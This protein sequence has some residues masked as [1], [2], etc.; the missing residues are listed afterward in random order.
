ML[1]FAERKTRPSGCYAYYWNC[2]CDCGKEVVVDGNCLK[3]GNVTSCGCYWKEIKTTHGMT[4]TR[5]Y[6]I[7]HTMKSRCLNKNDN[8]YKNYGH[9]GIK[10]CDEWMK[11]EQ[12][13]KWALSNGY[14]DKLTIDRINVNGNY[15]PDNCRWVDVV[16]QN[17]NKNTN[18]V[19]E[20]KGE[21][22]TISELSRISNIPYATLKYR[23]A[24]WNNVE[25]AVE[26][27][28]RKDKQ[29]IQYTLDEVF[30]KKWDNIITASDELKID[31]SGIANCCKGKQKTS[32]GYIW[33]YVCDEI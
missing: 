3:S 7:W 31:R 8:N 28:Y 32:G 29:I 30:V 13:S 14:S 15:C 18:I 6:H 9:R 33:K 20:Y 25:M 1:G 4:N 16:V 23:I 21:K 26:S 22:F 17:N 27:P 12:F 5:L 2:I 10:I 11:F 19:V 24:N